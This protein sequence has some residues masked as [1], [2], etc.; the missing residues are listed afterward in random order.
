[1]TVVAS[2]PSTV[3]LNHLSAG[4][5]LSFNGKEYR[6]VRHMKVNVLIANKDGRE[7]KLHGNAQVTVLPDSTWAD[8]PVK[9]TVEVLP[10]L[11]FKLAQEVV[12]TG[13]GAGKL[14]GQTGYITKINQSTYGVLVPNIGIYNAPHRMVNAV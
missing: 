2:K 9:P 10:F 8:V 1:M 3:P 11:R 12:L 5:I 6:V 14:E 4:T 13:R 7:Y